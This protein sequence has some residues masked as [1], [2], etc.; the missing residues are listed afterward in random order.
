M[1]ATKFETDPSYPKGSF[2]VPFEAIGSGSDS[3]NDAVGQE[4]F[5]GAYEYGLWPDPTDDFLADPV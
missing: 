4:A 5:P 3:P 1:P 2:E